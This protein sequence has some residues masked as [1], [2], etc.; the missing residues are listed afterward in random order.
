MSESFADLLDES[1]ASLE[2][3][4]GSIVSGVVLDI[5]KNWVT[6]H[7]GLKSEGVISIDEFRT[8]DGQLNIEVGDQIEVALEAVEDGYGETRISRE[9]ARKISTWKNLNMLLKLVNL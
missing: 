6:V 8:N 2:M 4:P 7:V 5:D 9:K 1:I 3:Q